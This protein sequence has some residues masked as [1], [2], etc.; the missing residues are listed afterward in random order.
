VIFKIHMYMYILVY[1][2]ILQRF[3][4]IRSSNMQSCIHVT[5]VIMPILI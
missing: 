4:A 3:D 1:Y 2:V 5:K